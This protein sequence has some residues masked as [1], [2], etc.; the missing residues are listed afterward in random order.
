[1]FDHVDGQ[2]AIELRASQGNP[3]V[4]LEERRVVSVADFEILPLAA[5]LDYMRIVLASALGASAERAVKMLETPWSGLPTGLTPSPDRS[6]PGLSYLGIAV[7]ALAGEARLLAAPVSYES[8]STA[9]AEGIEDR[10]SLA[11]LAARRLGD[12]VGLGARIVAIELTVAA[13]AG[14]LRGIDPRG[15]GTAAVFKRVRGHVPF[16][17]TGDVVPDVEPLADAVGRGEMTR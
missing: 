2:L 5:A 7:Q 6:D 10:T 11:P 4:V 16:L 14:E 15:E 13:Q 1:V 12:M 9:H 17:A 8:V 3:I